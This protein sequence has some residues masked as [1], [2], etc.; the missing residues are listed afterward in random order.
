MI[1]LVTLGVL[2]V[3]SASASS[4]RRQLSAAGWDFS[5]THG[6]GYWLYTQSQSTCQDLIVAANRVFPS[7]AGLDAC[8]YW[9]P[10]SW[11]G[12]QHWSPEPYNPDH[13][14]QAFNA[15]CGGQNI[16]LGIAAPISSPSIQYPYGTQAQYREPG[17]VCIDR[18]LQT[19]NSSAYLLV[20]DAPP[21]PPPHEPGWI[22]MFTP[23]QNLT[24][25]QL[26]DYQTTAATPTT[27]RQCGKSTCPAQ[28]ITYVP[29]T[30]TSS[31]VC[32]AVPHAY[33]SPLTFSG[34]DL[35][36]TVT[37]GTVVTNGTSVSSTWGT[38]ATNAVSVGF[39]AGVGFS[40]DGIDASA[41]GSVKYTSSTSISNAIAHDFSSSFSTTSTT[42]TTIKF[43]AKGVNWQFLWDFV[44]S[45]GTVIT[46]RT[47]NFQNTPNRDTFPCCVPGLFPNSST[48]WE[49]TCLPVVSQ[50]TGDVLGPSPL[51]CPSSSPSGV[52][53]MRP[54]VATSTTT[55]PTA[56]LSTNAPSPGTWTISS[57]TFLPSTSHHTAIP[58]TTV[59]PGQF[60]CRHNNECIPQKEVCDGV[61]D[62]T[63]HSDE[64]ECTSPPTPAEPGHSTSSD[65]GSNTDRGLSIAAI[66]IV[67][68]GVVGLVISRQRARQPMSTGWCHSPV[69]NE[70]I[71]LEVYESDV[72]GGNVDA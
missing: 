22:N 1:L 5:N 25:C 27:N 3:E 44:L 16:L 13:F 60:A 56:V 7:N 41:S 43:P 15:F 37:T 12:A 55:P 42:S 21:P 17:L 63:D 51:L 40:G 2:F 39:T 53:T 47:E 23:C 62:C 19:C 49:A 26:P 48:P 71:P 50:T 61:Y 69:L 72:D 54:S 20:A 68:V 28:N 64:F 66:C 67:T 30:A 36:H 35:S 11:D 45:N 33:W 10:Q 52:P 14:S 18:L 4:V 57:T 65:D 59:C 9:G 34:A 32:G 29:P 46:V 6:A 31:R 70:A 24:Q 58:T 38:T 8:G